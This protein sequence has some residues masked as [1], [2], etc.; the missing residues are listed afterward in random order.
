MVIKE[1]SPRLKIMP[2]INELSLRAGEL[3]QSMSARAGLGPRSPMLVALASGF[4]VGLTL[5]EQS[6]GTLFSD[7]NPEAAAR[8]VNYFRDEAVRS[9][10]VDL[11]IAIFYRSWVQV[12]TTTYLNK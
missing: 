3:A 10:A 7:L 9:E 5:L 12:L 8:V 2:T 11:Q 6:T 1:M 4:D